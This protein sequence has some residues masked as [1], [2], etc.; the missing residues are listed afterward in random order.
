MSA[1][2]WLPEEEDRKRL[3]R[4]AGI[5][6]G[7][8]LLVFLCIY[9]PFRPSAVEGE[10]DMAEVD[11]QAKE[12]DLEGLKKSARSTNKRVAARAV[13]AFAQS[14]GIEGTAFIQSYMRDPRPE[15]RAEAVA[16]W[17]YVG[18]PKN[19]QP[20]T[21]AIV[22]DSSPLVRSAGLQ[23]IARMQAWDGLNV[24]LDRMVEDEDPTVRKT[25]MATFEQVAYVRVQ[26]KYD[27]SQPK[28]VRR[29]AVVQYRRFVA[30][31]A[32]RQLYGDWIKRQE[33]EESNG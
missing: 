13:Q 31:P 24:V 18:T 12:K 21:Q 11:Q 10:A 23:V 15:V 27:P 29:A 6:L 16:G 14:S 32:A 26:N 4:L 1:M 20:I 5:G 17:A 9:L 8:P 7:V 30:Q 22:S 19:I 3:F 25:A 28:E 33:S 2:N